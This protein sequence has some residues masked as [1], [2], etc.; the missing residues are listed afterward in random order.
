MVINDVS[1]IITTSSAII[2]SMLDIITVDATDND[3][4]C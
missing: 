2:G 1:K 3:F 4:K